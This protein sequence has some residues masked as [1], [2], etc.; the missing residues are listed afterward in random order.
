MVVHYDDKHAYDAYNDARYGKHVHDVV[1][2]DAVRRVVMAD[3][4][5]PVDVVAPG[6]MH[7]SL[8]ADKIMRIC[9]FS[10]HTG[11]KVIP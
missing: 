8:L 7:K 1:P 11:A 9:I 4:V 6:R 2:E 10:Y 3:G 5:V